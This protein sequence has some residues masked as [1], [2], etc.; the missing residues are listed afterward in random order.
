M[1]EL[2]RRKSLAGALVIHA[3]V[4]LMVVAACVEL[5]VTRCVGFL[6]SAGSTYEATD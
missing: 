1:V 4:G 5:F 3:V 2:R 6:A